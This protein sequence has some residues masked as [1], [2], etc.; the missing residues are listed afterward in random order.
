M[1]GGQPGRRRSDFSYDLW[2]VEASFS[3]GALLRFHGKTEAGPAARTMADAM[4]NCVQ[5]ILEK[6]LTDA[7]VFG[8]IIIVAVR[9]CS[10]GS[11]RKQEKM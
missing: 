1:Q 10:D 11:E 8:I 5:R 7:G 6:V 9:C 4:A 2:G 3:S